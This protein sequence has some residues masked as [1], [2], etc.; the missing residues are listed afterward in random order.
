MNTC[1]ETAGNSKQDVKL[2]DAPDE[3]E[4]TKQY[5]LHLP[6]TYIFIYTVLIHPDEA[7]AFVKVFLAVS[8]VL[9]LRY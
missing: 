5:V 1:K 8:G 9:L 2:V 4:S 7:T 6:L 3:A